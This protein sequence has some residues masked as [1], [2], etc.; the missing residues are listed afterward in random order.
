[1]LLVL[2]LLHFQSIKLLSCCQAVVS[3][4]LDKTS[5]HEQY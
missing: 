2:L 3:I 5:S 1:M 4:A